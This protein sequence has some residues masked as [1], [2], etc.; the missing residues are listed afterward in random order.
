MDGALVTGTTGEE[1]ATERHHHV[2]HYKVPVD[3]G[4]ISEM[5]ESEKDMS[6]DLLT[7]Q[8]LGMNAGRGQDGFGAGG[9]LL[10]GLLVGALLSRGGLFGNADG[11]VAAGTAANSMQSSIDTNTILQ[12]LGDI[13]AAVPLAEGQMQLALAG[14]QSDITSQMLTQSM[15]LMNG[16]AGAKEAGVAA[17]NQ[18]ALLLTTG[19]NNTKDAVDS[20]STQVAIG[21]GVTNTNIERLGWQLSTAITN[22]GE[23]TRALITSNQIADLNRLAQERQ[24]EI[25]ELRH[26]ASLATQQRAIEINM[27]NNQNQNQLQF[28]QQAQALNTLANGL[29]TALQ[30]IQ[31]TNQAI[32]IGSGLMQANP[33]NTNTNVRA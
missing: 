7:A 29:A 3:V 32:N 13:K 16:I 17:A 9:G 8:A 11:N 26:N 19:F 20:L 2:H 10:G 21:Q 28:Q 5:K 24:D 22:D 25:I 18:N 14:A 1:V 4:V 30:N 27:T 33:T 12:S 23:K 15:A 6:A 31:A